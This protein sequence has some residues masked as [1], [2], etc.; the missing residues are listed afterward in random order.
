MSDLIP[1]ALDGQAVRSS[2]TSDNNFLV[3]T[4]GHEAERE[5]GGIR[6]EVGRGVEGKTSF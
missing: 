4:L 3:N 5:G 1:L 6:E 2:C